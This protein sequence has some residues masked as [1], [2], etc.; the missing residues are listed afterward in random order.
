MPRYLQIKLALSVIGLIVLVWGIRVD[1][2][3]VRWM[4]MAVLG[5]SVAMRFLPKRFRRLE[6]PEAG[7]KPPG[8]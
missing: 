5:A 4:G 8:T 1:D 7:S 3:N 6:G 2:P